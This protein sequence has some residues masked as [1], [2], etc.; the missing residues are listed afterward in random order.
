MR[1][2]DE[3]LHT[4][5]TLANA[6]AYSYD[7]GSITIYG[8]VVDATNGQTTG[9]VLGN[10]DAARAFPSFALGQ[11]P[12]TYV[13]APTPSGTASTLHVRV[14]ELLW[15]EVTDL[16]G[17]GPAQRV[18]VTREDDAHKTTLTFGNGVHGARLS[19]GTANVKATYRYGLGKGGNV[20][21]RQISQLATH[22]LGAQAVVNPLPATGGADPD[23]LEQARAN[24]P[25]TV[26]ALDRLVSVRDYAD[27]ARTY[28]G[29]GKAVAAHVSDGRRRVVHVTVAGGGDIP[30]DPSSDLYRNLVTSLQ[31]YGDPH[32]PVDVD[33]RRVKLIVMSAAVTLLPDYAWES[34]APKIRA[35]VL[36]RFAFDARDLGQT[37]FLSEAVLAAQSVTGVAYVDVGVFDGVPEN[38]GAAQ[39]ASLGRTLTLRPYVA[40]EAARID[41]AVVPGAPPR[42]L[43][44]ELVFMTPDIPDTLILTEAGA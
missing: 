22:P 14:N 6:L 2:S 29:I 1:I 17:A 23:T 21:A 33:V 13:S 12:L 38:V 34:V 20:D 36:A 35:A 25:S 24:A 32:Q 26:M 28:A 4:V 37:A 19:T 40:A 11:A 43:A 16:G 10:G 15:H 18:Y 30:I 27:F 3:K 44:A 39:L 8:N 7:R 42:I 9:E 41:R 5:L 31:T